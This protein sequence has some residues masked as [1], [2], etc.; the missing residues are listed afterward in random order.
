MGNET[1]LDAPACDAPCDAACGS[2]AEA[3]AS[4]VR[5]RHIT[6]GL[7]LAYLTVGWNLVEGI[8]ALASARCADSVALFGFGVDS[9]VECAS[10]MVII[11]RLSAERHGKKDTARLEA[12][13]RRARKGVA[14]SL[15]ALAGYVGL[16]AI[17]TLYLRERPTFSVVG[18]VLLVV[19]IVVMQWLAREKR[20]V[21]AAVRSD[22]M[23][24]DAAQTSACFWLSVSAFA[25]VATNG[26]L[27]FWWA[28][29]LAAVVIA[30]FLV[31]EGHE[32][33]KGKDCCA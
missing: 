18:T 10:S 33:W 24:A 6:R 12:V 30:G 29:P 19:S 27:G 32:A 26:A 20:R 1:R 7:N 23:K 5:T 21:A 28:D 22:A 15:F 17:R 13:E 16:A 4:I 11:W 9:F 2:A 3:P 14:V 31:R 25:G 8:V